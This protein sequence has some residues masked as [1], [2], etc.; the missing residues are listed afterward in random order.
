MAEADTREDRHEI[1]KKHRQQ[2]YEKIKSL[3]SEDQLQAYE[4]MKENRPA[5]GP[6]RDHRRGRQ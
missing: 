6:G 4:T 2:M 1:R 5:R 3:L